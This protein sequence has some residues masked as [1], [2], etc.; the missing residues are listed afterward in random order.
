LVYF[1][2]QSKLHLKISLSFDIQL[3]EVNKDIDEVCYT[4]IDVQYVREWSINSI[5]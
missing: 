2:N 3:L 4:H 1:T 5:F